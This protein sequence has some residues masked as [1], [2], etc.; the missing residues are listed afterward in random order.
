[1]NEK[2][3]RIIQFLRKNNNHYFETPDIAYHLK[4]DEQIA[5]DALLYLSQ[6]QYVTMSLDPQGHTVWYAA[7]HWNQAAPESNF[8]QL[9]IPDTARSIMTEEQHKNL[10]FHE[11]LENAGKEKKP[12]PLGLLMVCVVVILVAGLSL[13][14]GKW[15]V[16][17]RF[18]EL[19]IRSNATATKSDVAPLGEQMALNTEKLSFKIGEIAVRVDSISA[20]IDSLIVNDSL[21]QKQIVNLKQLF[22]RR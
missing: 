2:L 15:Y 8:E 16:D 9:K 3:Q 19:V 18:D 12:F 13:Y 11:L 14:A 22:R 7:E 17:S 20:A 5:N 6:I 21:I 1:M 10:T 4:L